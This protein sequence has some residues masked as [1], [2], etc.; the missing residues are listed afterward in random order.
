LPAAP[1]SR[2][3]F[4]ADVPADGRLIVA[5]GIPGRH[6]GKPGVEFLVNVGRHGRERTVLSRLVDP[7]NRAGDRG[8]VPLEVDLSPY[9]GRG[10]EIILETRGYEKAGAA[11]RAFWGTPTI[12]SPRDRKA[13]LVVVYLVD[14][15]R[16]DHLSLY[17]Y[18][19]DTSP[20]LE[21]FARDAVVF[22]QAI[23]PSSWT[24]PSVASLFTSLPPADHRCVQFYT[25]LDPS[26]VTLAERLR[27]HGYGTG[28]LVVNRLVLAKDAH[29]DQGF[30]YFAAPASPRRAEQ[31]VDAAL[32][33]LD[34][35]RGLPTFL[36]LHTMDAHTPYLPP[37]PFDR[38]YGPA[39]A[40]GRAAA[41][42]GDYEEPL[43]RER[44]VAQY[45]GAIAYGDREFGRLVRGLQARGLY[46]DA[47]VVFL[48]DHGEEFLDHGDW[49]HGHTLFDEL[50]RVPLVVKFPGRRHAGRRVE[51]QVQLVDVLPT[52]LKSQGLAVP[53][54]I[55]G[56]ALQD[57]LAG[58][59]EEPPAT[60]ETKYREYAAYGIRTSTE[61]YVRTLHPVEAELY[62]DLVRDP[63]ERVNRLAEAGSRARALKRQAE[64]VLA[65]AAF[66]Y[67][68]RAEGR[69]R[70]ELRIRTSGWI[71]KVDAVDLGRTER[72]EVD[73][74]RRRL[75]LSLTPRP[76]RAREV[77]ILLRPHG[78]PLWIE[79]MRGGRRLRAADVRLAADGRHAAVPLLY[80][81]VEDVPGAFSPPRAGVPGIALWL[82]PAARGSTPEL[83][84][85]ARE[86]LRALGYIR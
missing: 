59:A 40:P 66:H 33:F 9:A 75:V 53:R 84:R 67:R 57:S 2:L 39:P 56:R 58:R 20:E 17:G 71:E 74:S 63:R 82:A 85:E 43:D 50:V 72:A 77:G 10:T 41:E 86:D 29:F 45:D 23:A 69:D 73:A 22:D 16:A 79:G 24:K 48:S 8:W 30:T 28:A 4:L 21:R 35:R 55:A 52:V 32:A 26:F 68:L 65:P 18:P 37:P 15:L 3:R 38:R 13:P 49:V 25:P 19:R 51:R 11:D 64:A 36:Y 60:F 81:D 14:T 44:I 47:L 76:G 31:V 83:D 27:E 70:Y 46:D 80:P 7:A 1:P 6:Q 42:P 12:T 78:A 5:A 34:T 62:F 61:K 54:A